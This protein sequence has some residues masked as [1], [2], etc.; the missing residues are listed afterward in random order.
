VLAETLARARASG[1]RIQLLRILTDV[2]TAKEWGD[3]LAAQRGSDPA[4]D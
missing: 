4:K 1:Q 3:F 2:D